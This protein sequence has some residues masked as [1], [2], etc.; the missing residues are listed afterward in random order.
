MSYIRTING[1]LAATFNEFATLNGSVNN[2]TMISQYAPPLFDVE[3]TFQPITASAFPGVGPAYFGFF[4]WWWDWQSRIHFTLIPGEGDP[5]GILN[6]RSTIFDGLDGTNITK[7]IELGVTD[8]VRL[9]IRAEVCPIGPDGSPENFTRRWVFA[10][11]DGEEWVFFHSYFEDWSGSL[12]LADV[13]QAAIY[14]VKL[15]GYAYLAASS[16]NLAPHFMP[17]IGIGV[18]PDTETGLT[19][20]TISV[21]SFV[22]VPAG[23]PINGLPSQIVTVP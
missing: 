7:D 18:S 19:P 16:P 12:P 5:A 10:Y 8:P 3:A 15:K 20:A 13:T 14:S 2:A 22:N 4:G 9:R 23:T 1:M 11:H 21:C 17:R 6:L